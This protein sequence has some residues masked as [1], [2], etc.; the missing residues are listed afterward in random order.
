MI[1]LTLPLEQTNK[2]N[3]DIWICIEENGVKYLRPMNHAHSQSVAWDVAE[4]KANNVKFISPDHCIIGNT[5][6]ITKMQNS[7]ERIIDRFLNGHK[8]NR[9]TEFGDYILF[10]E[11]KEAEHDGKQCHYTVSKPILAIYLGC[12]VADQT[13]GFNYVRWNNENHTVRITNEYVTNYPICKEVQEIENH[14]E[15][16]DYIDILGHWK[17]KPKWQEII[18]AYRKQNLK[19][20]IS[21]SEF[22][23]V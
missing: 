21:S 22:I 9:T 10:Q 18:K 19:Q 4:G 15:W 16:D 13:L 6:D 14:I 23:I 20:N 2:M 8:N 12:F 11:Y 7:G 17:Q 3:K 1:L 5:Y